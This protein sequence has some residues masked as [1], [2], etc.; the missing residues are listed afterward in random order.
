MLKQ[1]R[2]KI[3]VADHRK[4]GVVA[5]AL[6][7]EASDVDFLVTDQSTPKEAVA[8]FASKKVLVIRA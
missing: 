8:P 2:Q 6:I 3:V 7:S 4:I 1:A 5:T